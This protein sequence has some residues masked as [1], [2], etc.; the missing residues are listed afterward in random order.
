MPVL[1]TLHT[2]WRDIVAFV[3]VILACSFIADAIESFAVLDSGQTWLTNTVVAFRGLARF[4]CAN[5]TAFGFIVVAWPTLNR[6]SNDSFSKAWT[7][8]PEWGKFTT[9]VGVCA[10]YLIA[11]SVCFSSY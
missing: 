5:L 3:V 4:G 10:V 1:K 7:S 11:A 6:F 8:L 2:N 9:F